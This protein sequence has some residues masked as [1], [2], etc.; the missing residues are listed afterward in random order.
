L[1]CICVPETKRNS[2]NSILLAL[3]TLEIIRKPLIN[4][5]MKETYLIIE[6]NGR[7]DKG[8]YTIRPCARKQYY[9]QANIQGPWL[10]LTAARQILT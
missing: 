5:I 10:Q 9:M 8:G 1:G 2:E 3:V 4:D 7:T 6:G